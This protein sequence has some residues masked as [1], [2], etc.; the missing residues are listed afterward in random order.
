M[1]KVQPELL[2][3]N[4]K[5]L[6]INIVSLI[7]LLTIFVSSCHERA[8]YESENESTYLIM[9]SM[10]GFRW[11]YTDAFHTPN[12]DKIASIGTKARS[13]KPSFPTKTF[14]NHYT[15]V[16]GLYPDHHG[17]VNNS[18]Y[19]P[20]MDETYSI[21]DRVSVENPVFYGGEP[22]WIT[23]EKQGVKSASFFW[24]GSEA[25]VM[26]MYPGIWKPYDHS[27]PF[28]QRIDTVIAWLQLP[29]KERPHLITWYV[30]EPDSKGHYLGPKNPEL[31]KTITYLDSLLGIFM[32]KLEQLEFS[33]NINVIVTSDHGMGETS[34]TRWVNLHEYLDTA[35]F[36][37][38]VGGNPNYNL[39]AHPEHYN[40]AWEALKNLP[41]TMAWKY[42][43]VPDRFHYGTNPRTGDFTLSADSSWI[44]S[45]RKAPPPFTGGSHGYDNRNTDMHTIFY[46]Y[47]PAFKKA[48]S[49]PTF[50][51]I[52]IYPLLCEILD[53]K[54]APVDG[55]LDNV[56]E[57]LVNSK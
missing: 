37:V 4:M 57:M 18:F 3:D 54:P 17:I 15:I 47:G 41:H 20:E 33:E 12:F 25:P 11:D 43:E 32:K 31:G 38:I 19:D 10:D 52:D 28:H 13:L 56:R 7:F 8:T 44:I 35:W 24:V 26:G 2:I 14:P 36:K 29:E 9:L 48:Y 49:H 50:D 6:K 53:L 34:S 1:K 55:N 30:N 39:F 42:G 16:T 51:N 21:S 40:E 46:G 27:F 45:W 22:I 5:L 23:A